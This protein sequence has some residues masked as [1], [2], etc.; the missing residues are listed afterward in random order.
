MIPELTDGGFLYVDSSGVLKA[1]GGGPPDDEAPLDPCKG[2]GYWAYWKTNGNN[3][4]PLCNPPYPRI[5]TTSNDELHV[6]TNDVERMVISKTG[7]IGIGTL[8]PLDQFEVHT[9]A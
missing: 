3:L 9:S 8:E 7:K 5:G 1:G 2:P 4:N 6:I